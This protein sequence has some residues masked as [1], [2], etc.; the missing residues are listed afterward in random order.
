MCQDPTRS[1]HAVRTVHEARPQPG[2][3]S[4][5]GRDRPSR[6]APRQVRPTARISMSHVRSHESADIDDAS[7]ASG[8]RDTSNSWPP[9]QVRGWLSGTASR[10]ANRTSPA[11]SDGIRCLDHFRSTGDRSACA[12]CRWQLVSVRGSLVL[13]DS[14]E[15]ALMSRRGLSCHAGGSHACRDHQ[16]DSVGSEGDECRVR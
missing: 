15:G 8:Q 9:T 10:T 3:Q 2:A 6:D 16:R 14:L 11:R 12:D 7:Q 5:N 1:E 13:F 4:S